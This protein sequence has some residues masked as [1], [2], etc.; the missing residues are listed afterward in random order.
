MK[1]KKTY[2]AYGEV[3]YRKKCWFDKVNWELILVIIITA[4]F[5]GNLVRVFTNWLIKPL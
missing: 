2:N 4:L 3:K 1:I 5:W